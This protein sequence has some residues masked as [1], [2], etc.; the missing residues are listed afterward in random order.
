MQIRRKPFFLSLFIVDLLVLVVMVY[1]TAFFVT[2]AD[3][4][5]VTASVTV[6]SISLTVTDG[7]VTYGVMALNT[8]KATTAGELNDSQTA[9]NTG[10]VNEDF[11]I[12]GQNTTDWTLAGTA[13]SEQY[14]HNFSI[15]GGGAWTPLTLLNQALATGKAP[16][17]TQVFDLKIHT[18]TATTHFTSQ[19]ADVSVQASAS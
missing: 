4:A 19:S 8:E 3:Q 15:N 6:Q 5:T 14:V 17:G 11:N 7:G 12:V 9:T 13:G 10:N 2:A 18:P 16:A 1:L